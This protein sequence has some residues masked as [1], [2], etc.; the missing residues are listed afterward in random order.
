VSWFGKVCTV[1]GPVFKDVF[2]IADDLQGSVV[3]G[4]IT[5]QTQNFQQFDVIDGVLG[6]I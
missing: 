4:S 2:K 5:Y 3:F 6:I 1:S